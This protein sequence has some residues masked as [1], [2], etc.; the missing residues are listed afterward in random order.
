MEILTW[1]IT[2][3]D[4]T[5]A[6]LVLPGALDATQC[7]QLLTFFCSH[8]GIQARRWIGQAD[9]ALS[10]NT[11]G[12]LTHAV[13]FAI[14]DRLDPQFQFVTIGPAELR[15]KAY[16]NRTSHRI[17]LYREDGAFWEYFHWSRQEAGGPTQGMGEEPTPEISHQVQTLNFPPVHIYTTNRGDK[18]A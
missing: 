2:N 8:R 17:P 10:L 9:S 14:L 6:R 18:A 11:T 1:S 3:Q 5:L 12:T 4:H 7:E 16:G 15:G 13:A